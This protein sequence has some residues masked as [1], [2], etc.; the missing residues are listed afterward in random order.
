MKISI[1]IPSYNCGQYIKRAIDSVLNQ[2]YTDK[3][4][5]VIDG[6]SKD[7]TI[8][9][10]KSYGEKIKW[11]SEKD[12]GQADAIN[13]G[14][15][16]GT[17]EIITWLNAD[18]YYEPDIFGK[19]VK[20]FGP[21]TTMVYGKCRSFSDTKDFINTPP[22]N[23]SAKKLIRGGNYIYQPASFYNRGAVE[24]G[25]G[26]DISLNYWME[27]DL[28]I[29]LFKQGEGEFIDVILTNFMVREGQKSDLKNIISM[30][31]ELCAISKKYGGLLFSKVLI[32][33]FYHKILY[34][35]SHHD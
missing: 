32:S 16:M 19:V 5:I 29:K 11:I 21:K 10:L 14:F 12:N 18:D 30:D 28:F 2:P 15:K 3:E 35:L 20:A 31:K 1:I 6:G 25:G 8:E 23:L 7:D 17:G 13:K 24:K 26:I 4:L 27:Y 33:S 34:F 9:I 22:R